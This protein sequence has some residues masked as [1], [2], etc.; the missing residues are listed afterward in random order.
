MGHLL[1]RLQARREIRRERREA[2]RSVRSGMA[3]LTFEQA[4]AA[5]S[6]RGGAPAAAAPRGPWPSGDGSTT[7]SARFVDQARGGFQRW[8]VDGDGFLSQSD[9]LRAEQDPVNHGESAA[10]IATLLERLYSIEQQSDDERGMENSGVTMSDLNALDAM[11]RMRLSRGDTSVSNEQGQFVQA[12]DRVRDTTRTPFAHGAPDPDAI[13]QGMVGSCFF[14][15]AL[16]S[17]AR[18]DPAAVQRMITPLGEGRYQVTFPDHDPIVVDE[19]TDAQIARGA[20]AGGDGLWA[21]LLER[22]YAQLRNGGSVDAQSDVMD[23]IDGGMLRRGVRDVTGNGA[24]TDMLRFR[25]LGRVRRTVSQAL[26]SGRVVTA[27]TRQ[28]RS[29]YGMAAGN[30]VYEVVAFDEAADT[31]TLRNPWGFGEATAAQHSDTTVDG[32]FVLTLEEFKES[33]FLVSAER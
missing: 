28:H 33:F 30:H 26:A 4:A 11:E 22:A 19:P 27:S 24:N 21:T 18:Q 32:T 25:T 12:L 6:P 29:R 16:A 31:V 14:L 1:E 20:T 5:L 8:D 10:A 13:R 17:R 9:L 23:H 2:G 15:S 7:T 3:G